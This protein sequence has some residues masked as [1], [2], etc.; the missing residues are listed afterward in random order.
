MATGKRY[1]WIKLKE[2][3]M[4]SD[5]VDYLM[6]LPDGANYVVLYQMLCL[7]TINTDGRLLRRIG[8]ILI[9]YDVEKIKRDCKW[10]TSDTI[11]VALG[12]YRSFGLIYEDQDGVLVLSDHENL[13]G[14]ETDYALQKKVQRK[15]QQISLLSAVDSCVDNVHQNV[16]TDIR[17][18]ILDNNT[19]TNAG[20]PAREGEKLAEGEQAMGPAPVDVPEVPDVKDVESEFRQLKLKDPH[21]EAVAFVNYNE[22]RGWEG[23]WR[24]KAALWAK[25]AVR[26]S[27]K[28]RKKD[29]T[30]EAWES[31][32]DADE[33]FEAALKRT[34]GD[35]WNN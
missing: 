4:T 13:I 28:S 30:N 9:P 21:A 3:F 25:R 20:A 27:R 2:T 24:I 11:R 17:Y 22:Q 35:D 26:A 7:K 23:D 10:F 8:E 5:T 32:F 16:H 1:Y 12:L 34:Y 15:N 14:S 18:K 6:G 31:S 33:Y 29:S 19:H